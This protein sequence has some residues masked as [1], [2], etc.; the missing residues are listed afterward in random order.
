LINRRTLEGL[1]YLQ[2]LHGE[3]AYMNDPHNLQRFVDAQNDVFEQVCSE[4]RAGCK[5]SHWMWYIFPQI[6]GLGNS[7][8]SVWFAISSREEAEAY[9][10]H[11]VLGPRLRECTKLVNLVEG[12]PID[13]ILGGIDSVKFRSSMTLFAHATSENQVFK[14]ALEKYFGGEFDNLTLER[15]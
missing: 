13:Q 15:L 12:R 5:S 10:N 2:I 1:G 9:L 3:D 8:T 4:L 7:G 6:K 14:D 11:P